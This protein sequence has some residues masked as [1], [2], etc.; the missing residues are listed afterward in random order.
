MEK[1]YEVISHEAEFIWGCENADEAEKQLEY[2]K[3]ELGYKDAFVC[4]Y[5]QSNNH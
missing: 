3:N 2:V 4:T 5:E 1:I